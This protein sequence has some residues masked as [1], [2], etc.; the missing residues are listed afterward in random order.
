MK[1]LLLT[2]KKVETKQPKFKDGKIICD[3]CG[4]AFIDLSMHIR[5]HGMKA[6]DYRG[7]FGYNLSTALSIEKVHRERVF[8]GKK[9]NPMTFVD[10]TKKRV[11][12][13][14]KRWDLEFDEEEIDKLAE[15]F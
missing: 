15:D 3:E 11:R 1:K 12:K 10:H 13:E 14:K 4:K 2:L 6:D 5:M 9:N 7:K 8:N